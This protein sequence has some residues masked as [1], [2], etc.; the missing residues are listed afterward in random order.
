MVRFLKGHS[1]ALINI[2]NVLLAVIQI[3]HLNVLVEHRWVPFGAENVI[4]MWDEEA[5]LVWSASLLS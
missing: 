3:V 5:I 1:N 2:V 4:S